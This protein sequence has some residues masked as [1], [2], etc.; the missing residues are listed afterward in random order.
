MVHHYW[1][2]SAGNMGLREEAAEHFRGAGLL[3]YKETEGLYKMA[4]VYEK[5]GMKE[6]AVRAYREILNEAPN[7]MDSL[8]AL[9]R[10]ISQGAAGLDERISALTPRHD[11]RQSFGDIIEFMG[12][13]IDKER[14][15]PGGVFMISYLW[16]P[17]KKIRANYS[18]FVHFRK[19][20][21]TV[22]Q[23]D[24][25]PSMQTNRWKMGSI[26]KE[27]YRVDVPPDAPAGRYDIIIGLWDPEGTKERLK[28][29]DQKMDE[30]KIGSIEV[31]AT[32]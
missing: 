19:D 24:R 29:K 2:L 25:P 16:R 26:V 12:Y 5:M 22:F 23:N 7:H 13:G 32:P 14:V 31:S 20:G 30:L 6:E 17:L 11:I 28:L 10:L 3:G 21:A 8:L 4:G 1:G 18:I 15:S 27:G 9:R